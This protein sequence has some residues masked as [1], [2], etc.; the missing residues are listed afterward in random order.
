MNFCRALA[1]FWM[2]VELACRRQQGKVPVK[3]ETLAKT[4]QPEPNM[5]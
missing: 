3:S 5:S 4:L 2:K 1:L